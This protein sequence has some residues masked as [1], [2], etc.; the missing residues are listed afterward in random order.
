MGKATLITGSGSGLGKEFALLYASKGNNVVLVD[1][2]ENGINSLKEEINNKFKT[3]EVYTVVVD[4]SKTE[5]YKK[6]FRFYK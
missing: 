1:I 6:S 3:V 2:N 5:E 4:L